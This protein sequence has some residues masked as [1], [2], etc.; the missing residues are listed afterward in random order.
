MSL[1][2]IPV[3]GKSGTSRTPARNLSIIAEFIGATLAACSKRSTP[4]TLA[5]S[6]RDLLRRCRQTPDCQAGATI[7]A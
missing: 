6:S 1:K 4:V 2:T 7:L 5:D 3:F